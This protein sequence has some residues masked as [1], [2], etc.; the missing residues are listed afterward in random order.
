MVKLHHYGSHPRIYYLEI[1]WKRQLGWKIQQLKRI[2]SKFVVASSP[3]NS[4]PAEPGDG[5]QPA[6]RPSQASD[7]QKGRERG[8]VSSYR[9]I[10]RFLTSEVLV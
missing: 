7:A 9:R 2:T 6:Q 10:K 4:D 5:D 8:D 3:F 1:A